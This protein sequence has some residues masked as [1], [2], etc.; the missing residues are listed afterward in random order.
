MIKKMVE[1]KS[2]DSLKR[3]CDTGSG[4]PLEYSNPIDPQGKSLGEA[5]LLLVLC[6]CL[7]PQKK[8][9]AA[10]QAVRLYTQ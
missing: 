2:C 4:G 1:K 10:T 6:F 7:V 3:S 5:N 9:G 8:Q